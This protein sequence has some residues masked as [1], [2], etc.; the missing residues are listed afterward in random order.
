MILTDIFSMFS[1]I[2]SQI[3]HS[4]P[5]FQPKSQHTVFFSPINSL[6]QLLTC[7]CCEQ[8]VIWLY[9]CAPPHFI[10][11]TSSRHSPFHWVLHFLARFFRRIFLGLLTLCQ[12]FCRL[13]TIF[14]NFRRAEN[15][16]QI[17]GNHGSRVC[18][19]LQFR[20]FIA[21]CSDCEKIPERDGGREKGRETESDFRRGVQAIELAESLPRQVARSQC[22]PKKRALK[23]FNWTLCKTGRRFPTLPPLPHP[24]RLRLTGPKWCI[25]LN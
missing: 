7:C 21:K 1:K 8:A 20:I 12:V 3:S 13:S 22:F 9:F 10:A 5:H 6:K 23:S 18:C 19:Q 15:A 2:S 11:L 16:C 14:H 25:L 17:V 4:S 24:P